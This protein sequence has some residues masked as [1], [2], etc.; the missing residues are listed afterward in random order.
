[1]TTYYLPNDNCEK[2]YSTDPT[3]A[4]YLDNIQN[5]STFVTPYS[6]SATACDAC[7]VNE[8]TGPSVANT[9]SMYYGE[10]VCSCDDEDGC[11]NSNGFQAYNNDVYASGQAGTNSNSGLTDHE[12]VANACA[13][14]LTESS[15]YNTWGFINPITCPGSTP[16]PLTSTDSEPTLVESFEFPHTSYFY[17]ILIIGLV[18][19]LAVCGFF[20]YKGMN[21]TK[22]PLKMSG[23]RK[24][25]V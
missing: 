12:T 5:N 14:P 6:K 20:I 9:L 19:V 21:T 8:N 15:M 7:T 18:L 3:N 4:N 1:M 22:I 10:P 16:P 17:I 11:A 23:G 25:L 2:V 24:K 13:A